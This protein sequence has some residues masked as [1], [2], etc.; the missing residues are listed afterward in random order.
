MEQN[1]SLADSLPAFVIGFA[2]SIILCVLYWCFMQF[3]RSCSMEQGNGSSDL[4]LVVTNSKHR[5]YMVAASRIFGDSD[6][7]SSAGSI[8]APNRQV[9]EPFP[10]RDIC[11]PHLCVGQGKQ[12]SPQ[13]GPCVLQESDY[14][15][16][17]FQPISLSDVSTMTASVVSDN[18]TP[19]EGATEL[20][21]SSPPSSH[22]QHRCI[23]DLIEISV[24][25]TASRTSQ[26]STTGPP[27]VARRNESKIVCNNSPYSSTLSSKEPATT[28]PVVSLDPKRKLP[29]SSSLVKDQSYCD[30]NSICASRISNNYNDIRH[31]DSL[32]E[33]ED[34][35]GW[36]SSDGD[37][38]SS[39]EISMGTYLKSPGSAKSHGSQLCQR[40]VCSDLR[41]EGYLSLEVPIATGPIGIPEKGELHNEVMCGGIESREERPGEGS[42]DLSL[43]ESIP[44]EYRSPISDDDSYD[45]NGTD[46]SSNKTKDDNE[47]QPPKGTD[48]VDKNYAAASM[49]AQK[50]NH[51][52][53]LNV[54]CRGSPSPA[55]KGSIN[56]ATAG[57]T[58]RSIH[59]T[60]RSKMRMLER[61]SRSLQTV[62]ASRGNDT[63]EVI[64]A[65]E[66]MVAK[67]MPQS[68]ELYMLTQRTED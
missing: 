34:E 50:C 58:A 4:N 15:S 9:R 12:Q 28:V 52:T 68:N 29:L 21:E 60:E 33:E 14:P 40:S 46:S 37:S 53:C 32:S 7:L 48:I 43:E 27:S 18:P 62:D 42:L 41:R 31:V 10:S 57:G 30:D 66:N 51:S 55:E 65:N 67:K 6:V 54:V 1:K 56:E 44:T 45:L 36:T 23:D 63:E 59:K 5:Q 11:P 25:S 35:S 3:L 47:Q 13:N 39:S 19:N 17:R 38:G 26:S 20:S 16:I 22:P 24:M 8:S 2:T 61:Q 49:A 64:G